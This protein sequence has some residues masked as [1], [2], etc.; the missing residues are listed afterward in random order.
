MSITVTKEWIAF[1]EQLLPDTDKNK[2]I[3]AKLHEL[4]KQRDAYQQQ[5]KLIEASYA[6]ISYWGLHN[7]NGDG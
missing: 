4:Y 1:L 2:T 7:P 6:D 5:K 3:V